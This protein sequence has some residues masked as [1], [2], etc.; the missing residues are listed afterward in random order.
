LIPQPL[1]EQIRL[2]PVTAIYSLREPWSQDNLTGAWRFQRLISP[3]GV[4]HFSDY[5]G[6]DATGFTNGFQRYLSLASGISTVRLR[7]H[8]SFCSLMSS[9]NEA[10]TPEPWSANAAM[11]L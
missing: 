6:W 7:R 4:A 1:P 2:A 9:A 11:S 10:L 8:G 3:A 5:N